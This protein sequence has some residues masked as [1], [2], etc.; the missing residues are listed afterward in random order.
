MPDEPGQDAGV[1]ADPV[2]EL[3]A[4]YAGA[5]QVCVKVFHAPDIAPCATDMQEDLLHVVRL[6]V[7]YAMVQV[8]HMNL[9]AIRKMRG[10]SQAALGEM[11]GKDAATVNR[12]EAMHRS[13]TLL[14][15]KKCADALGVTLAD[16]LTD[17]RTA[18]ESE[19]VKIFR[20]IPEARYQELLGL[21]RLAETRS[22]QEVP[23]SGQTGQRQAD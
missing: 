21:L 9:T 16:L 12:A 7:A 22:P 19:L 23:E 15:Y 8:S 4:R 11:I 3:S 17:E 13:A 6:P 14:T 10:L 20:G 2:G 18:L 1:D 5:F